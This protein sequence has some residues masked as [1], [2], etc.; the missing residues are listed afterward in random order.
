MNAPTLAA[1]G[2]AAVGAGV[3]VFRL[4]SGPE[5]MSARRQFVLAALA[6]VVPAQ[7]GDSRFRAIAPG[8]DP[9]DPN[10][11]SGFT[12][13]GYL[14]CYVGRELGVS[15]CITQGGL[16]QMRTNG[17]KEGSWVDATGKNRPRPGDLFGIDSD[18]PPGKRII[19]HVGA[20]VGADGDVWKTADAGQ[21]G[22]GA[23]QR[24]EY[25]SRPYDPKTNTLGGPGA[26]YIP[27]KGW[28]IRKKNYSTG[29]MYDAPRYV[30][31]WVDIDRVQGAKV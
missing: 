11:P 31:G 30:A 7:Y 2:V 4:L 8:Y 17:R 27:G 22:M 5:K 21:G 6:R 25:I 28:T 20:I 19:V 12:T 24:A 13:C 23:G 15:N 1:V 26:S 10:L 14:P 3:A 16:E 18:G 29:Q 9:A